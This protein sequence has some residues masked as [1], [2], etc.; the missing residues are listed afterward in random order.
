MARD[1]PEAYDLIFI[2]AAAPGMVIPTKDD[3]NA[4]PGEGY[5]TSELPQI[6]MVLNTIKFKRGKYYDDR[7]QPIRVTAFCDGVITT[8]VNTIDS[9]AVTTWI[10]SEVRGGD[11]EESLS[12]WEGVFPRSVTRL[13]VGLIKRPVVKPSFPRRN[14]ED[15]SNICVLVGGDDTPKTVLVSFHD[16]RTAT[17][18]YVAVMPCVCGRY[19]PAFGVDE[20]TRLL[21]RDTSSRLWGCVQT[22]IDLSNGQNDPRVSSVEY[23]FLKSNGTGTGPGVYWANDPI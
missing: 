5:P 17:C 4:V 1:G 11:T 16:Y 21:V 3:W 10:S 20:L 19:V 6:T 22:R 14:S 7:E 9:R 12:G 13:S 23:I 18:L 2:P 15:A 8:P